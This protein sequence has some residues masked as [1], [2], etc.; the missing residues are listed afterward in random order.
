MYVDL[1]QVV[2]GVGRVGP[3]GVQ[4]LGT[5][6]AV[7]PTKVATA[8]HVVGADDRDLVMLAPKVNS[9]YEYQDTSD[10]SL[11]PIPL[12]LS[13]PD[14]I[15]DLA[16][17]EA[18]G[19]Q[20]SFNYSISGTDAVPP[21]SSI[22]TLGFPHANV[23]RFV[24]TQQHAHVGARVLIDNSGVKSKHIVLNTQAREGQSGGPVFDTGMSS[25][26]AVLVGSFAPG[27]GG[28]ISLGGVDPWTLHQTT[29]AVSAEYLQ[30]ML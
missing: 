1:S 14:P 20:M 21:P 15:R 27:G 11:V 26:V 5:C 7:A 4:L 19:V 10:T 25:L 24:L 18:A 28:G 8:Y 30:G 29:H 6:F 22:V 23:G 13:A 2:Y 17:L 3:E 9:L 12:K 16:V